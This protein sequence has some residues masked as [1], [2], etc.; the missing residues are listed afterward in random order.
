MASLAAKIDAMQ[1]LL[2]SHLNA[3]EG[4]EKLL[5][6][7]IE[8]LQSEMQN[9][10]NALFVNNVPKTD[11]LMKHISSSFKFMQ[12]MKQEMDVFRTT[13]CKHFQIASPAPVQKPEKLD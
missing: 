12:Y 2:N 10:N 4:K 1:A 6:L 5:L 13:L 7:S 9:I 11:L 8:A 3:L